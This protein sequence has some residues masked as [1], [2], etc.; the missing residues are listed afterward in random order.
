MDKKIRVLIVD[1]SKVMREVITEI[2][3]SEP[4]IEVVGSACDG[5]E[6]YDLAISL[7]PDVITM[8][9]KMPN[10]SGVEVIDK[11][12]TEQPTPIIV[13]SSSSS[14]YISEAL[15]AGAMDFVTVDQH[16][17]LLVNDVRDKIKI[18][19]RIKPLRRLKLQKYYNQKEIGSNSLNN[20]IAIGTSTGGPHALNTVLSQLPGNLNA[21]VFIVQHMSLGFISGLS[22]WLSNYSG[23]TIKIAEKN[24]IIKPAVVYIAP[25]KVNMIVTQDGRIDLI[26]ADKGKYLFIPSINCMMESVARNYKKK[27]IGVILTGMGNDGVDGIRAIKEQGGFTIAQDE[28][29]SVVY[30]MNKEAV[31]LNLIDQVEPIDRISDI[32]KEKVQG[33]D[34]TAGF[35]KDIKKEKDMDKIAMIIDDNQLELDSLSEVAKDLG[36]NVVKSMSGEDALEKINNIWPDLIIIDAVLGGIDGYETCKRIRL[37]K[38]DIKQKIIILTGNIDAIDALK[39]KEVGAN[40]FCV[41]TRDHLLITD[42]INKI[43]SK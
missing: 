19:S 42:L 26:E 40:E 10:M 32:L 24:E 8:D 41:K 18:A 22:E 31:V 28:K 43:Y 13:I 25:D 30:G 5:K 7:K 15:D 2:L 6:G 29:S 11:I 36:W 20:V 39:A 14:K 4:H 33:K 1:D 34:N 35:S 21:A 16:I 37:I 12:M 38:N 3:D 9:L 23:L 27:V 17:D